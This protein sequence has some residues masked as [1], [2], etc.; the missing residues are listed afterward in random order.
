M[1]K[2]VRANV[3]SGYRIELEFDDGVQ[4]VADLS[5]LAG[6]GVFSSWSDHENFEKASI[7]SLGEL[8]WPDGTDLC[9]DS[10]YLKVTGKSPADIFPSLNAGDK[11]A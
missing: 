3:L 6:K 10:L 7:G 4:G 8:I 2:I 1:K 11:C 9:P 5:D